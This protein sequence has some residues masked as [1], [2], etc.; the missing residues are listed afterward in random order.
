MS[1]EFKKSVRKETK[2]TYKFLVFA[3]TRAE[4][5]KL[6]PMIMEMKRQNLD[7][8]VIASGQHSLDNLAKSFGIKIDKYL[9]EP[10]KGSSRFGFSK[11][12]ALLWS[13]K[14]FGLA[15]KLLREEYFKNT[16]TYAI[17]HGD[18]LSSCVIGFAAHQEMIDLIHIEAGLRSFNNKE[19]FPEELCRRVID[20]YANVFFTPTKEATENLKGKD[21]VYFVG[22]TIFDLLESYKLK[23]KDGDYIIASVHR[24]ENMKS[25]E[26]MRIIVDIL[27]WCNCPVILF[28]HDPFIDALN[29]FGLK[30]NNNV[31]VKKLVSHKEVIKQLVNS[32]MIICD[33]GSL[34]EE[35]CYYHKPFIMLR[36][37]TE[38]K[39]MYTKPGASKK[40][41]SI[42]KE[43]IEK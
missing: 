18:T 42:L 36:A 12:K 25:E 6:A 3:S 14:M 17:V 11:K 29:K 2:E 1:V 21:N 39:E 9:T 16:K 5:I 24:Q 10:Q 40:I 23:T 19:P 30:L 32:K 31:E 28:A 20:R 43:M 41:V 22:N 27:N 34:Y 33:G 4:L 37:W 13:F 26:R 7:Y 35:G 8:S 15:R 38:R